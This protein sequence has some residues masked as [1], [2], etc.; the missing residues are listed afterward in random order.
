MSLSQSMKRR[1]ELTLI[2][3]EFSKNNFKIKAQFNLDL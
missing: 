2:H 1:K 3:A